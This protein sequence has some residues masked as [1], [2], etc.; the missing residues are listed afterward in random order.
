LL[1]WCGVLVGV[2]FFEAA[3]GGVRHFYAIRN[4]AHADAAVRDALFTRA[5]ELD[6]TLPRPRRRGRD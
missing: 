6:A 4:R 2:G 1:L 3:A 5:L